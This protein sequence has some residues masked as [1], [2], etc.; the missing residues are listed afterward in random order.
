MNQ[1]PQG[2]KDLR[3]LLAP[4]DPASQGQL[5][6]RANR[7]YLAPLEMWERRGRRGI[8]ACRG[9]TCQDLGEIRVAWDSLEY[10][11][12]KAFQEDWVLLGKMGFQARK[13]LRGRWG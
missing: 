10:Q 3:G 4:L 11:D 6:P 5:G 2:C 12:L 7:A 9:W 8:L 1:V 13:V